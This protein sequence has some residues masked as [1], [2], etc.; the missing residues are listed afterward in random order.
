MIS[1]IMFYFWGI[2][3]WVWMT[4]CTITGVRKFY[5]VKISGYPIGFEYSF[6]SLDSF[7]PRSYETLT[8]LRNKF[9]IFVEDL[10][11]KKQR[12]NT[13]YPS[14][15]FAPV[16]NNTNVDKVFCSNNLNGNIIFEIAD[17]NIICMVPLKYSI[18]KRKFV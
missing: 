16:L 10:S 9:D 12:I 13:F 14:R 15:N 5:K 1:C 3:K 11:S 6:L 17:E 2:W 4:I 18:W 8:K 7:N